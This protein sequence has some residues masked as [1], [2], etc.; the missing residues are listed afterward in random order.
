[1]SRFAATRAVAH[2]AWRMFRRDWRGQSLVLVLLTVAVAVSSYGASLGHTLAPSDRASFGSAT[3]RI[4]FTTND[5]ALAASTVSAAHRTFGTVEEINDRLIPIPGS[6]RQLDLRTQ[7]PHGAFGASILRL[8]AGRYPAN[9][10]GIALTPAISQFLAAP[11]GASVK[12][13]G[14]T[15]Q[16]VGL[17][18]NPAQLDDA[19]GLVT[20][21]PASQQVR[22]TLLVKASSGQLAAFRATITVPGGVTVETPTYYSRDLGVLLV[23]ALGMILVAVL[24]L[25]AF[26]V[27]AQRR[28]RQLG[29]LAAIGATRRQVRNVTVIHGLILGGIAA[30][31]GTAV[32]GT[33]WALTSSLIAQASRRRVSWS[34]VPLWLIATPGVMGVV[35]SA[36]AAWWPARTMAR[37]PIVRALSNRPLDTPQGRRSATAAGAAF[38]VGVLCLRFAHQRNALLMITGLA[39]MI[40][41][42]LLTTPLAIRA[43]TARSGRLPATGRLAWRELGRNQS[44]SAAALAT[45]TIAV[46]ISVSAVVITAANAHPATAGNL[47]KRQIL[48]PVTDTRDPALVP[49]RT[50][51]Q[52]NA[53]DKA[54]T[55]VAAALPSAD[56][57][58]LS[59]AV[60]PT[61][62]PSAEAEATGD[63]D[64]AQ[65]VRQQGRQLQ[66]YPLY[67][68]S[69]QVLASLSVDA[70]Q[71]DQHSFFAINPSGTWSLLYSQRESVPAPAPLHTHSYT[72]LPQVLVSPAVVRA[73]H[74]RAVRAGWLLQSPTPL[75][76][77]QQQAAR[78]RAA[79]FG[80]AIETR[81]PQTY[82]GRLRLL[83]T[84]GGIA[85]TLAVIAIALVLLRIQTTRDQQI[86]TAVGAPRRARRAI[87]ATTATALATLGTILGITGAYATL[88][89][90]YSDTLNRLGNIPWPAL[91]TIALGIP[92]LALIT[93]WLTTSRQPPSINRPAID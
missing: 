64:A 9:S 86:L 66:S 81:D 75:T 85:I 57:I 52:T 7:D 74:W 14:V 73:R 65:V 84:I 28:V 70:R 25:T 69:P 88:I 6:V 58:P 49:P 24:A 12:L 2:W 19:F 17:V 67:I 33:G 83:F 23:A 63:L 45:V 80:L 16:V 78:S 79:E 53:L 46:G 43:L 18:E 56:L 50:L 40:G 37:V 41:S 8:R 20:T 26:L 21:P 32:A 91:T 90:A 51:G 87:A 15:R 77:Q 13:G 60:D 44:R 71:L 93:T 89:L 38:A 3:G 29:M 36:L 61:A 34:S 5:P 72:S 30:V 54:A 42:V 10:A 27:L 82:L 31:V 1:M 68:A 62:P 48:I 11:V 47:A 92:V 59:L 76:A 55:R 35:A 4:R 22:Y 39:A